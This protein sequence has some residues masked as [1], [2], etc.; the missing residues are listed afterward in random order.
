M[1]PVGR[2]IE[3]GM[4]D[5]TIGGH[6]SKDQSVATGKARGKISLGEA[7]IILLENLEVAGGEEAVQNF[8][9]CCSCQAIGLHT[10][11]PEVNRQTL[12]P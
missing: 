10:A 2:R 4:K 1:L 11:L 6:A 9:P 3:G 12:E 5:A 8:G 7:A